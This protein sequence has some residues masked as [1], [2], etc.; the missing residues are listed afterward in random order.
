MNTDWFIGCTKIGFIFYNADYTI[1]NAKAR[2]LG[3]HS[4]GQSSKNGVAR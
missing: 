1:K 2:V 3:F 4:H